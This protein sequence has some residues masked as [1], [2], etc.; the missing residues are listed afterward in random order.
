[1]RSYLRPS[2]R[3][4][5]PSNTRSA[6]LK[7]VGRLIYPPQPHLSHR[8]RL[9]KSRM[10]LYHAL[11]TCPLTCSEYLLNRLAAVHH[12]FHPLQP[13]PSSQHPQ[14]LPSLIY[15]LLVKLVKHFCRMLPSY[16]QWPCHTYLA[17]GGNKGTRPKNTSHI[18]IVKNFL[19]LLHETRFRAIGLSGLACCSEC[20]NRH[21]HTYGK[22]SRR[23]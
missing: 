3:R 6:G 21:G 4:R 23:G 12:L 10:A 17:L 2:G 15:L 19:S 9:V 16:P 20:R 7:S 22:T 18:A 14:R 1:M 5:A 11:S 8:L 13:L